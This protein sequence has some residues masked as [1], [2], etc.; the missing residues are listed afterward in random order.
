MKHGSWLNVDEVSDYFS[1][2]KFPKSGF[3]IDNRALLK[4]I[5]FENMTENHI[6]FLLE[7]KEK[8]KEAQKLIVE[9]LSLI[10]KQL[11]R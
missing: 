1:G 10:N 8:Q 11:N 7:L 3:D 9:I 6:N 2:F 5:Q 4:E